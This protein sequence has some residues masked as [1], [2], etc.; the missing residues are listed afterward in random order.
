[1]L[2]LPIFLILLLV[3]SSAAGFPAESELE[4]D[5][6]LESSKDFGMR[7]VPL[8]PFEVLQNYDEK[9]DSGR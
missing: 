9:D 6:T 7:S 8:P 4:R 2:R 5:L 3:L 1:M